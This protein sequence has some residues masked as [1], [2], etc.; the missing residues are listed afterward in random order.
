[1]KKK[2]ELG[3]TLIELLVVVMILGILTAFAVPKYMMSL[4]NN[5][6][7]DAASLAAMI[8]TTTRLYALDH[9]ETFVSAGGAIT[10]VCN[11]GLCA[12]GTNRCDLVRCS[13][14]AAQDWDSKPY[15]YFAEDP[16]ANVNCAVGSIACAK[17]RT[18]PSPGT[19]TGPYNTWKYDVNQ[20]GVNTPGGS[21][22]LPPTPSN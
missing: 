18:G 5:K 13:Y 8:A 6:A 19:D 16:L 20:V 17:R 22:P 12:G 15:A 4:E 1:M 7:E 21:P 14:L 11:S 3:F 2:N 9:N 10:N